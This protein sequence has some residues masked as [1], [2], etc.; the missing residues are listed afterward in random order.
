MGKGKEL[1]F[2][3]GPGVGKGSGIHEADSDDR[4]SPLP[5]TSFYSIN[6]SET[7]SGGAEEGG[8][9]ATRS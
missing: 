2:P 9:E 5:K 1:E 6:G 7:G 4:G 3:E 8:E